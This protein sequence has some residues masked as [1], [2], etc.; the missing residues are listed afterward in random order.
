MQKLTK[1]RLKEIQT[2]NESKS[3]FLKK[4]KQDWQ[5]LSQTNKKREKIQINKITDEKE[6]ITNT[7]EIQSIYQ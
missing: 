5:T 6:D 1:W 2:I 7:N 3:W 4:N